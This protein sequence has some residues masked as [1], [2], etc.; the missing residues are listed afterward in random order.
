LPKPKLAKFLK[1]FN[2]YSKTKKKLLLE[3]IRLAKDMLES[4]GK[5]EEE[6]EKIKRNINQE[7]K[8][9]RKKISNKP[10]TL[11]II[12][13]DKSE[14]DTLPKP[15]G[16]IKHS[17]GLKKDKVGATASASEG[18]MLNSKRR[19]VESKFIYCNI[20]DSDELNDLMKKI[21]NYLLYICKNIGGTVPEKE[22]L[23]KVL[24]YLK[25]Y[26][27]DNPIHFLK[28]NIY[29]ILEN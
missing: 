4:K 8:P 9:E 11:E 12:Q 7:K 2:N 17:L 23:L 16:K 10:L 22:C 1:E 24:D 15:R 13:A 25:D 27:I 29:F 14:K 20:L 26:K 28:V 5:G 19:R 3:S 18:K 21:I 6:K